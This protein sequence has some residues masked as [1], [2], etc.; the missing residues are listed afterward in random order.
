MQSITRRRRTQKVNG[1]GF[2][3]DYFTDFIKNTASTAGTT[4]SKA[5]GTAIGDRLGASLANKIVKSSVDNVTASG[6][7][8]A[9]KALNKT[10]T[11]AITTLAL[12]KATPGGPKATV[13]S[14]PAMTEEQF[15]LGINF[16]SSI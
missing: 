16:L 15:G 5:V 7:S 14:P 1:Y 10:E 8:Y 12:P 13:R 6:P 2:I 3:T 11:P 9:K 4:V